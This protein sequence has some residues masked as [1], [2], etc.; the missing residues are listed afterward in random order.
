MNAKCRTHEFVN[1][2]KVLRNGQQES[3]SMPRWVAE[4]E[5]GCIPLEQPDVAR[6]QI[7]PIQIDRQAAYPAK[8]VDPEQARYIA[9]RLAD[10][11]S[12]PLVA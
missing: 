2:I 9:L 11:L 3:I 1:L 4:L 6:V 7:E 5:M 12:A 8:R 10:Y